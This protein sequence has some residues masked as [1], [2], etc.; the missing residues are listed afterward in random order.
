MADDDDTN[1][2]CCS[3]CGRTGVKL[4]RCSRCKSDHYSVCGRKCQ[5]K[6]WKD[7]KAEDCYVHDAILAKAAKRGD[8][9][10]Q[11]KHKTCT[12]CLDEFCELNILRHQ[13]DV[14]MCGH[15]SHKGCVVEMHRSHKEQ[16]HSGSDPGKLFRCPLCLQYVGQSIGY[17]E[18]KP[19]FQQDAASLIYMAI[20]SVFELELETNVRATEEGEIAY[21]NNIIRE[22]EEGVTKLRE[23]AVES[24]NESKAEFE[25]MLPTLRAAESVQERENLTTK[26]NVLITSVVTSYLIPRDNK[27]HA[28]YK[29]K[30][31]KYDPRLRRWVLTLQLLGPYVWD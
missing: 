24:I 26:I 21:I 18:S 16:L 4:S 2:S 8:M 11:L 25:K 27:Q 9:L 29:E 10:E 7:H 30:A 5:A 23:Y 12:I 28:E 20:R 3:V 19:W 13:V 1:F 14:M 22:A 17:K 6:D 31:E 15:V